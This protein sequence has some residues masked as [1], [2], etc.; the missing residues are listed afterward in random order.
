M[1][2]D[3]PIRF[4][5]AA[6]DRLPLSKQRYEVADTEI[7]GFRVRVSESAKTFSLMYRNAAGERK[8][9]TIG[10]HG[11]LT[12]DQARKLARALAGDVAQ[13]K[14]PSEEKRQARKRG[15]G[16]PTLRQFIEGPYLEWAEH[17]RRSVATTA[18]RLISVFD[19]LLDKKVTE[20]TGWHVEKWRVDQ[21]KAGKKPATTDRNIAALKAVLNRAIE[22]GHLEKNPLSKFRLSRPDNSRVRFLSH[23]EE[24][25]LRK[26]LKAREKAAKARKA[27]YAAWRREREIEPPTY[28][29]RGYTHHLMPLVLLALNTGARRGELFELTW[30]NVDFQ[31]QIMTVAAHTAKSARTR[32]IPLNAEALE[33]LRRWKPEN[34]T[35]LVF[36]NGK[37]LTTIKTSW[38]ALIKSAQIEKFTFHDLRHTFASKLIMNGVSLPVVRDLLGHSSI[39]MTERYAHLTPD[40]KADAVAKLVSAR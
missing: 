19:S 13:G 28:T 9:F 40:I 3:K 25:R 2:P 29:G 37:P 20:I 6:V 14:D 8:R 5:K 12:M 31:R 7:P 38:T 4:T 24:K 32:H 11:V 26:A 15:V 39:A 10:R 35:G 33:V 17:N 27:R 1:I 21:H 36:G 22:A 16:T 18:R 34:A 30:E 23:V